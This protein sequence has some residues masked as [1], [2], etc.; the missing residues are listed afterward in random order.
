M[1]V[2]SEYNRAVAK[3]KEAGLDEVPANYVAVMLAQR[4]PENL[5]GLASG[6][7]DIL[8]VQRLKEVIGGYRDRSPA[9]RARVIRAFVSEV[10][11]TTQYGEEDISKLVTRAEERA[12]GYLAGD[13]QRLV[14]SHSLA[15]FQKE[16]LSRMGEK[17]KESIARI[18]Q[19]EAKLRAR[20]E[21]LAAAY[22][23]IREQDV[24]LDLHAE[25][26]DGVLDNLRKESN[27]GQVSILRIR[28]LGVDI[29]KHQTLTHAVS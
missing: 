3:L 2:S 11:L 29:Q 5:I 8:S 24:Q 26:L 28:R 17:Q 16:E 27:C 9:T 22:A 6:N 12:N 10:D 25:K 21:E 18:G 1:A 7:Y 19:L 23:K 14:E 4:K 20:G 15:V 13:L